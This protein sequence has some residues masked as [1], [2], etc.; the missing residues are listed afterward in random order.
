MATFVAAVFVSFMVFS[1]IAPRDKTASI[2]SDSKSKAS[3]KQQSESTTT[4]TESKKPEP[5]QPKQTPAPAP[6]PSTPAC[7]L[8][9]QQLAVQILGNTAVASMDDSVIIS[10]TSDMRTSTCV[11]TNG[12]STTSRKTVSL[13]A[14]EALTSLGQSTNTVEFGSGRPADAQTAVGFGQAAFWDNTATLH[15]LKNNN[16]YAISLTN[17]EPP[18]PASQPD[19]ELAAGIIVPKL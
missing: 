12:A 7:K 15:V 3:D 10:E 11:Y 14:H 13:V 18:Q 16:H 4:P 2:P 19:T 8:F 1:L 9:T 6:T 5:A 17:G